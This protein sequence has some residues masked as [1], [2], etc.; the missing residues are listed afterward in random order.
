MPDIPDIFYE[1]TVDAGSKPT[2]K[3]TMRVR[4]MAR[5][6]RLTLMSKLFISCK[7]FLKGYPLEAKTTQ[8]TESVDCATF[9]G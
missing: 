9:L 6:Q 3:E 7:L 4:P 5:L 2:Y 1:K 8:K